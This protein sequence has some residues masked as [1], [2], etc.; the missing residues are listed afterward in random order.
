[1]QGIASPTWSVAIFAARETTETLARCIRAASAACA[2]RDAVIDVLINGN[3]ALAQAAAA[4]DWDAAQGRVRVWSIAMGD[5][6]HTWN[7]YLHRIWPKGA[8]SFCIDGYAEVKP[9]ALAAIAE[10]MAQDSSRLGAT[11]VPTC[12][13]SAARL[14]E[15]MLKSGGIHGNLYAVRPEAMQALR[16]Q[17]FRLPLGLYRTDPLLGSVL[18]FGL[19]PANN[20]WDPTRIAVEAGATWDVRGLSDLTWNNLRSQ[21]KRMVRQAQGDLESRAAREHLAVKRLAPHLFPRTVRELVHGWIEEHPQ[22]ARSLFFKRPL[23]LHAARKL[24]VERD[25]SAAAT[26]PELVG[27]PPAVATA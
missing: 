4:M 14:R 1:M 27:G 16:E 11:G 9:G 25:W 15:Q 20:Q 3:A 5:K 22:Q 19:D 6:A 8:T 18:M 13:R 10:R 24:K 7:E 21:V 17:G 2:G 26:P 23:C 12:G